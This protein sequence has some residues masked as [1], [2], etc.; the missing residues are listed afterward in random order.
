MN[1]S[2]S[3]QAYVDRNLYNILILSHNHTS[4]PS[5]TDIIKSNKIQKKNITEFK[6]EMKK[7]KTNKKTKKTNKLKNKQTELPFIEKCFSFC[8]RKFLCIKDNF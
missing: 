1:N 7:K 3:I 6:K 2:L 4:I 8:E 5:I